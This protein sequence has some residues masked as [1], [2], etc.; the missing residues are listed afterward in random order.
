[1]RKRVALVRRRVVVEL[2]LLGDRHVH[3][4]GVCL[5]LGLMRNGLT[6]G[7]L[8]HRLGPRLARQHAAAFVADLGLALDRSELRLHPVL[9]LVVVL[10]HR[11]LRL[12]GAQVLGGLLLRRLMVC[13]RVAVG[14]RFDVVGDQQMFLGRRGIGLLDLITACGTQRV[15]FGASYVLVARTVLALE[16]EVL[17]DSVIKD[18]HSGL[19]TSAERGQLPND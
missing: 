13:Q 14:K 9:K 1:M 6:R 10:L 5:R 16:L 17:P 18:P 15:L 12:V 11:R 19:Q 8:L 7:G 2:R 3:L 4:G